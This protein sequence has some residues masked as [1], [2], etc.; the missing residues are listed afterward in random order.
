MT[1]S[2]WFTDTCESSGCVTGFRV[3]ELLH[4]EQTSQQPVAVYQSSDWGHMLVVDGHVRFT[5]RDHF[6][7]HEMLAHP[8]LFTHSHAKRVL[9]VGGG[10]CGSLREVLRHEH[11]EEVTQVTPDERVTRLSEHYFPHLC[12]ANDDARVALHFED[13]D[14]YLAAVPADSV[15]VLIVDAPAPPKA[16]A[17]E[18]HAHGLAALRYGGIL[19]QP[20][21]SPMLHLDSIRALRGEL[22]ECGF[23]AVQTLAFP[24]SCQP[25][26]WGSCTLAR[27]GSGLTSFRERAASIK[28]F[29]T[30]YYSAGIHR[31]ALA[32]PAFV[33]EAFE[34]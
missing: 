34:A 4:E 3:D 16:D 18:F 32:L 15:D 14:A 9:L 17:A 27:K 1:P 25:G 29:P 20:S 31:A 23:H 19:V 13:G 6:I 26:G 8:A 22:L 2:N 12:E 33:T 10:D 7:A 24:H 30:R 28:A 21:G 11:V 5:G